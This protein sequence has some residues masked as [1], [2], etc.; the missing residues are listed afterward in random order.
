VFFPFFPLSCAYSAGGDARCR[1]PYGMP[2]TTYRRALGQA[3][4][5]IL[6]YGASQYA[7]APCVGGRFAAPA[8][9]RFTQAQP[10]HRKGRECSPDLPI[11]PEGRSGPRIRHASRVCRLD[12]AWLDWGAAA[13]PENN[14]AV[15]TWRLPSRWWASRGTNPH[16]ASPGQ[17]K[18]GA[19]LV[20]AP[21]KI[22]GRIRLVS[23]ASPALMP[24]HQLPPGVA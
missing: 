8:G 9:L 13:Q 4:G 12:S 5:V 19:K 15:A 21:F 1:E 3:C 11:K 22:R 24:G 10:P 17:T 6:L 20:L 23:A 2:N 16:R 14:A 7:F 18:N